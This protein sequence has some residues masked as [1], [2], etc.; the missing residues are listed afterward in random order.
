MGHMIDRGPLG[1]GHQ[2]TSKREE[3]NRKPTAPEPTY[4]LSG[5][6]PNVSPAPKLQVVMVAS[7]WNPADEGFSHMACGP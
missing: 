4:V 5:L 3:G 2:S 1:G 7:Q 6:S